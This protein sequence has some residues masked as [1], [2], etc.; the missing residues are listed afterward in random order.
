MHSRRPESRN[1]FA[2]RLADE[3]GLAVRTADDWKECVEGADIVV[4]ASRLAAPE[5]LLKTAWIKPGAL[6]IPY[7]TMS[8]VE[9][10]L[11]EIMDKQVEALR[12]RVREV[13]PEYQGDRPYGPEIEALEGVLRGYATPHWPVVDR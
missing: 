3:L 8:A 1:A 4:E 7:G 13:V 12:R 5:P 6:V 11:I 10:D 9:L 2:A